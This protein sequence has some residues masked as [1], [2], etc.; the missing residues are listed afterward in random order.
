MILKVPIMEVGI[1]RATI[2]VLAM[3]LK[4][5]TTRA[6]RIPPKRR[7]NCTSDM[8]FLIKSEESKA[9]SRFIPSGAASWIF[10]HCFFDPV[11]DVNMVCTGSGDDAHPDWIDTLKPAKRTDIL[12][13]VFCKT[14]IFEPYRRITWI[15]NNK[16][17]EVIRRLQFT[18]GFNGQ[19]T[20]FAFYPSAGRVQRFI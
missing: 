8:E 14:D 7:S 2:T 18:D 12:Y 1:A 13:P 5:E 3:F 19:F 16:I 17:I 9:M 6:A 4:K 15:R 20:C 11:A 10:L